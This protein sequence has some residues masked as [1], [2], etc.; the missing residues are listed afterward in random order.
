[1]A[2]DLFVHLLSGLHH[3]TGSRGPERILASGGLRYWDDG[4][5]VPDVMFAMLDYGTLT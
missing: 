1:V 4:R 5:D 3:V 2:G